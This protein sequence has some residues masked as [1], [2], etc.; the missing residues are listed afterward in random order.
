MTQPVEH[1]ARVIVLDGAACECLRNFTR[2]KCKTQ[3]MIR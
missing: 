1:H 3:E 2:L